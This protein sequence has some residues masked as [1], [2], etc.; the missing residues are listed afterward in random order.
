[1][2]YSID[3][4]KHSVDHWDIRGELINHLATELNKG[5]LCLI[6][7]AGISTD[8]GLPS[9]PKLIANLY[10]GKNEV[11]PDIDNLDAAEYYKNR[12][13]DTYISDVHKA[14]FKNVN[15]EFK[16]LLAHSTLSAIGALVMSSKRGN[17]SKV[18]SFNFDNILELYLNYFGFVSDSKYEELHWS[19]EADVE[20]YHPHGFLSFD[21][22]SMSEKI[23]FDKKSYAEIIGKR[24]NPWNI[25]LNSVMMTHTCIF[26]GLSGDDINLDS[27]I[28]SSSCSHIAIKED[29]PYW[30]VSL[31]GG[32]SDEL[33]ALSDE[34]KKINKD[35]IKFKSNCLKWKER[36]IYPH[37]IKNDYSNLADFLLEISQNASKIRMQMYK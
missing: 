9:W 2:S 1:M 15:I 27:I 16:N 8:F 33:N 18:I 12:Y 24:D 5:R 22:M 17:S 13:K 19:T 6:L 4:M 10:E 20:I 30:G 14:L 37:I 26:L 29:Y 25:H 32:L 28:Q 3:H 34:E 36:K 11:L 31:V 7:G 35:V 21:G 23:V